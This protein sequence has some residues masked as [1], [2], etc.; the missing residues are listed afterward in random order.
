MPNG[1]QKLLAHEN[2]RLAELKLLIHQFCGVNDD[3]QAIAIFL[4]LR[5]LVGRPGVLDRE[6]V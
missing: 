1:D 5:S 2:M 3:E 6:F 4:D